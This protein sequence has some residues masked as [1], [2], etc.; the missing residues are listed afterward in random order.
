[1]L[2]GAG[3]VVMPDYFNI[4]YKQLPKTN[5]N[6]TARS[7]GCVP[8]PNGLKFISGFNMQTMAGD[9]GQRYF[10]CWNN[11]VD[12]LKVAGTTRTS[13]IADL[14]K[15][16]CPAGALLVAQ[17]VS[18]E[19]WD[20][21]SADSADHRSHVA[22]NDGTGVNVGD[23]NGGGLRCPA[24]WYLIPQI[25]VRMVF[26]TDAN[27]TAGKWSL[28]SDAM[29]PGAPA[30]STLHFDYME[31]WSPTVKAMWQANCIDGHL[32]CSGGALGNG[33]EIKGSGPP[34]G[35]WVKHQL[36][37]LSSIN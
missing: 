13:N 26:T 14:V 22:Y 37:P 8:L 2:D 36:V 11:D 23:Q 25:F 32:S 10:E 35:G 20:G 4:Y 1:M 16:G 9:G 21:K 5:P 28:A 27:F 7:L 6:C 17:I 33:Q 29:M 3:N 34:P 31:G 15:Q 12:S 19:C 24:G 30:G 18:Q